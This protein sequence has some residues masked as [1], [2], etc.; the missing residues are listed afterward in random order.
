MPG[1]GGS[2]V[3]GRVHPL[4]DPP[5]FDPA[6]T[7]MYPVLPRPAATRKISRMTGLIPVAAERGASR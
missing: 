2:G 5:L 6:L 3:S 1:L 4:F 7:V